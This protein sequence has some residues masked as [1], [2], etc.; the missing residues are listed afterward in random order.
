MSETQGQKGRS[1]RIE[2]RVQGVGFRDYVKRMADEIGVT[3]LVRNTRDGAVE[4]VAFG[5]SEVL[6]DFE[7]KLWLGPGYVRGVHPAEADAEPTDAF[8]I[9]PT[10]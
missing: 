7:R 10:R 2:G 9:A 6:E 5:P 1:F 8:S 3:G 4:A